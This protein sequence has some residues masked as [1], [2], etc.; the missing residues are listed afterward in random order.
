M[1]NKHD[2]EGHFHKYCRLK[3]EL[4][5]LRRPQHS[6][7][8]YMAAEHCKWLFKSSR[9]HKFQRIALTKWFYWGYSGLWRGLAVSCP[10]RDYV[11]D[12]HYGP[13]K[14]W[15]AATAL[16]N[17][18]EGMGVRGPSKPLPPHP[19]QHEQSYIGHPAWSS[20][21]PRPGAPSTAPSTPPCPPP[22][23]PRHHR[24]A[25]KE[26]RNIYY[27]SSVGQLGAV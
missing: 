6:D 12:G 2:L 27:N 4:D 18:Y 9:D 3:V 25:R 8:L 16:W 23:R 22:H 5:S 11:K 21:R 17:I 20:F 19:G 1:I 13:H 15:R 24:P 10:P 26:R 7:S 14:L